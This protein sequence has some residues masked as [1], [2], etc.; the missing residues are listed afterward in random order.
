MCKEL[1]YLEDTLDGDGRTDLAATGRIGSSDNS[2]QAVEL[3][4]H[5]SDL[6]IVV[7]SSLPT[8]SST[9]FRVRVSLQRLS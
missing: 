8:V 5:S 6:Q 3:S 2:L 4:G 1:C 7:N 9:V